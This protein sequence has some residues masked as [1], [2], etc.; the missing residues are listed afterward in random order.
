MTKKRIYEQF[1]HKIPIHMALGNRDK[2][3]KALDIIDG[4]S[5]A[6]RQGNGALSDWQVQQIVK[7]YLKKMEDF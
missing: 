1:L 3:G 7:G 6:H 4:W 2:I 5:Y